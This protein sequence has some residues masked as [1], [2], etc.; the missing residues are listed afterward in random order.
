[1]DKGASQPY[2]LFVFASVTGYFVKDSV[3]GKCYRPTDQA[4]KG[5]AFD[6]G[7]EL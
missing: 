2:H 5:D 6:Q 7:I 1:M 4:K 3:E